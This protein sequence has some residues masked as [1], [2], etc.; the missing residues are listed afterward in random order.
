MGGIVRIRCDRGIPPRLAIACDVSLVLEAVWDDVTV[1]G[2][3]QVQYFERAAGSKV[4][5]SLSLTNSSELST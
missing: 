5:G 4:Q 3:M 1:R 2:M